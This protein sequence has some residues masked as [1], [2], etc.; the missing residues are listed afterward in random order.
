MNSK[1]K[2]TNE[3]VEIA[4]KLATQKAL[5]ELGEQRQKIKSAIKDENLL[6][7]SIENRLLSISENPY[8]ITKK[9]ILKNMNEYIKLS[10]K[11]HDKITKKMEQRIEEYN[12]LDEQYKELNTELI[13]TEKAKDARILSLREKCKSRNSTIYSLK[14]NLIL[15]NLMNIYIHYFGFKSIVNNLFAMISFTLYFIFM[16]GIYIFTNTVGVW[17]IITK[18]YSSYLFIRLIMYCLII[19]TIYISYLVYT[20]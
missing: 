14:I 20:K 2:M 1:K 10:N 17:N 19:K 15:T 11:R 13:E 9:E 7:K 5:I 18:M 8:E 16:T 12:D 6:L 3:E 4:S